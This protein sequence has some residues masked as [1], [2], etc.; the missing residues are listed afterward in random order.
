LHIIP[1]GGANGRWRNADAD[2]PMPRCEVQTKS[3]V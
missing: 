3:R 1:R 2:A